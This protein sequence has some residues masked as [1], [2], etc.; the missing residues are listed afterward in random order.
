MGAPRNA[1]RAFNAGVSLSGKKVLAMRNH[2]HFTVR[3]FSLRPFWTSWRA[4]CL[5]LF[6]PICI[7]LP[8]KA[9]SALS[10]NNLYGCVSARKG[11]SRLQRA[12]PRGCTNGHNMSTDN[13]H[14]PVQVGVL[15]CCYDS[16]VGQQSG[17]QFNWIASIC[18]R[19]VHSFSLLSRL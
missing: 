6:K 9:H 18:G 11:S 17:S 16:N 10:K 19:R 7:R 14:S 3:R 4:Y 12:F 1:L 5:A 8:Y 13:K 2:A 15:Y